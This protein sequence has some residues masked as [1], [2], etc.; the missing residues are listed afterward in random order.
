MVGRWNLLLGWPIFRGKL[1][2]SGSDR[3]LQRGIFFSS[4]WMFPKI[5]VPPK[6]SILTGF[7]I[8]NHPFW[9]TPIFG[10]T[11]LVKSTNQRLKLF[12]WQLQLQMRDSTFGRLKSMEFSN[13]RDYVPRPSKGCELNPKG[14]WIDT[15]WLP[16]EGAGI[17]VV[18]FKDCFI[19]IACFNPKPF[20]KSSNLTIFLQ[21]A[22]NHQLVIHCNSSILISCHWWWRCFVHV[23]GASLVS[24]Q[25]QVTIPVWKSPWDLSDVAVLMSGFLGVPFKNIFPSPRGS[26]GIFAD[27]WMV[28]FF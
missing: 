27:P 7:S 18:F 9:G 4:S 3:L 6:S 15:I 20:W 25:S 10:N 13:N 5:V 24:H 1:L 26:V 14:W 2:V 8:I 19:L 17:Q 28:D 16:F 23:S 12:Q 22:W 21:I 11:Q